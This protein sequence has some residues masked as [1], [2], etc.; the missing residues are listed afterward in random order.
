MERTLARLEREQGSASAVPQVA[1]S[2]ALARPRSWWLRQIT[3][4]CARAAAA[5]VLVG[6]L[7]LIAGLVRNYDTAERVGRLTERIIGTK[8]TDRIERIMDGVLALYPVQLGEK[9]LERLVGGPLPDRQD[10]PAPL[11][12]KGHPQSRTHNS[13]GVWN[14]ECTNNQF[15]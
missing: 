7:G 10:L 9:D 1:A 13:S 6:F 4:P 15:A 14:V 2:A 5:L 3:N 12:G 8:A 11:H